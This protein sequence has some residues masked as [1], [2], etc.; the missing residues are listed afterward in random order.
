[1][2]LMS[3]VW[4]CRA[5]PLLHSRHW[6]DPAQPLLAGLLVAVHDS[7]VSLAARGRFEEARWRPAL[8]P[9]PVPRAALVWLKRPDLEGTLLQ[10]QLKVPERS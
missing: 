7:P 9:S 4:T 2:Y 1:M 3:S 8:R 5:Y 6:L 10:L